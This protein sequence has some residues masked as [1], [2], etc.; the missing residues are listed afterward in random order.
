MMDLLFSLYFSFFKNMGKVGAQGAV[1]LLT[2]PVSLVVY[3]LVLFL[4]S[5]AFP[6]A[7][8]G[9]FLIVLG[10][11]LI[12]VAIQYL[13]TKRYVKKKRYEI[14]TFKYLGIYYLAA[15]LFYLFSLIVFPVIGFILL[16]E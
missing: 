3:T 16:S 14:I 4:L 10:S 5:F 6:I 11:I 15:I 7:E 2:L 13:F 1:N 9:T 8:M 12:A